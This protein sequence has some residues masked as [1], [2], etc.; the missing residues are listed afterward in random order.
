[1]IVAGSNDNKVTYPTY[2]KGCLGVKCKHQNKRNNNIDYIE[3]PYGSNDSV[4]TSV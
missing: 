1:M 3:F 4:Q 2:F